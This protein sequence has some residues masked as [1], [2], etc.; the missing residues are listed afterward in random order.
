VEFV[1]STRLGSLIGLM[2]SVAP[3]GV[4]VLTAAARSSSC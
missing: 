4:F 3:T 1:D 2:K